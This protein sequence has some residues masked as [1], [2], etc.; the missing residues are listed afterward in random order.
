M[1]KLDKKN[2]KILY[3]LDKNCRQSHAQ[4][5]R[6][7]NLSKNSVRYRINLMKKVGIIK[8]FHTLID[9]GKLGYM[10]FR[11]YLN[12]QNTTP[13]KEEELINYLKS[14]ANVTWIA[15]MDVAYNL[16]MF[17]IVKNISDIHEFWD[18]LMEKYINYF[19][20]RLMTIITSSTYFSIGY[21][22]DMERSDYEMITTTPQDLSIDDLDKKILALLVENA[23]MSVVDIASKLKKTSKT[24]ILRIRALE[25]KKV[26]VAYKAFLDFEKLGYQHVKVSFILSKVTN[27]KK[28]EF[29]QYAKYH[30]NIVYE[31]NYVGGDDIEL[32]IHV[33]D[34]SH[35]RK[36]LDDIRERFSD[37]IHDHRILQVY[38]EYKSNYFISEK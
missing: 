20:D 21:L 37:I 23:D 10:G 14:C 38:E 19:D 9:I 11:I 5:G 33:K 24:I 22:V 32:G 1:Y 26:I 31:E 12:L 15:S 29:K 6:K 35:L 8:Q 16:G 36:I 3:E 7:V 27:Q 28:R 13:K 2:K 18:A 34:N 17:V 25:K 4:I 30:P